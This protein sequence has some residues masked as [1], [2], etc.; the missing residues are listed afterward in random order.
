MAATWEHVGVL[1]PVVN[2]VE[3]LIRLGREGMKQRPVISEAFTRPLHNAYAP[4]DLCT[5]FHNSAPFR[6]CARFAT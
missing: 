4:H 6:R 5:T 1:L 3:V 2:C